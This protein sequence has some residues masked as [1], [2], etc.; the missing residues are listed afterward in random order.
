[1]AESGEIV[2]KQDFEK[3]LAY[4]REVDLLIWNSVA[5]NKV[6]AILQFLTATGFSWVTENML[7]Q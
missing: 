1:M 2:M 7:G 6:E 4:K 5:A 3:T